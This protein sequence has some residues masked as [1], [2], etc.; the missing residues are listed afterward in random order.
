MTGD[1]QDIVAR[2]KATL[3][4]RWFADS[5]PILDG[6]VTGLAA[7][8]SALYTMLAYV[9][10]QTRLATATGS[11]LDRISGDFL[12]NRLGR[13]TAE[14][15]QV[16]RQR[17][18]A[19]LLR[20]RNTRTAIT[21]ALVDLTDRAPVIFEPTRPADTG[22]WGIALAY[23]IA[24][25]WGSLCLP[26]QCLITAFR[27]QGSGIGSVSG[28]GCSAGGYGIGAIE[29]AGLSML[30]GEITD[31]DINAAI[32]GVMPVSTIAWVRISN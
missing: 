30:T 18:K 17:I 12:G 9:R 24:G 28:Y 21:A 1:L 2:L 10:S 11:F 14:P 5:T 8:W 32:A 4:P 25:G 7:S 13:R 3:P 20:E 27:A 26:F 31:A 23:G 15:D 29:Y 19:E 16:Y 6:L 22:G